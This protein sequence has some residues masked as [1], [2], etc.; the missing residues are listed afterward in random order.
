[1]GILNEK[2]TIKLAIRRSKYENLYG[3]DF[4]RPPALNVFETLHVPQRVN[5]CKQALTPLK[6]DTESL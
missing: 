6:V 4:S 5:F 3:P 1:M 2:L